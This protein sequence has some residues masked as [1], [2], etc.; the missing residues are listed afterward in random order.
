MLMT[1]QDRGGRELSIGTPA[2]FV[3]HVGPD[4][5]VVRLGSRQHRKHQK[6]AE[7]STWWA[8]RARGWWIA[9][10]FAVGSLLFAVGSVPGYAS[11][12]GAAGDTVTYF[13]G[14]LFFTAASS[15]AAIQL[16]QAEVH[17]LFL[18]P[19]DRER[20][21]YR[22]HALFREFLLGELRRTEPDIVL[23]LHQRAADW[24]EST[25]SPAQAVEHLLQ[26]N[27]QD[28]TA[29]LVTAL[30]LPTYMAGQ[31]S[32]TQRWFRAIGDMNIERYPLLA[33]HKCWECVLTGDTTE[34]LRWAAIVDASSFDGVPANGSASFDSARALLRAAMC[35]AGPEAMTADA[36]FAVA[37][38]P[39]WGPW[40]DTALWGLAE[41][42]LLAGHLDQARALFGEASSLAAEMGNTDNMAACESHLAWLAM[43]RGD[44]QE[45]ACRL[46]AALAAIE[47]KRLHD[48]V[49]CSLAFAGAG[50]L[51][52]HHG[53][54]K[55]ARRQLARAMRARPAATYL[56]PYL[57][58]RLRLR[59]AKVH[60]AIADQGTARQLLREIDDVL[61]HR[62]ALGIL[63]DEVDEFRR[64]LTSSTSSGTSGPLPLTPAELRLLPYL[65]THLTADMIAE[66][67]FLS[68]HTVKTQVKAVYR[69]LGVS[70]RN[71][72][73]QKATAIG[74][75][76]G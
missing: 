49:F 26:T 32:T 60:L 23:T 7:G 66:R 16:R 39:P 33:L 65:Q 67:L 72:A 19:L 8:P 11:A 57:A 24:Y 21:W 3:D 27:D 63:I 6:P 47:E 30:V 18:A 14:S 4:G 61:S 59:L 44:W 53:D 74:L 28:R 29:R 70:S 73:V 58:V 1:G 75:L 2:T 56:V 34:S 40:R 9:I 43:D 76:G 5:S 25:G 22:Y 55:E 35:A 48:Y 51:S 31:L 17:H 52:V 62:P 13:I 37:Q 10:L 45:A 68:V 71:D 36:T 15:A 46:K 69:K 20:Q 42:H 12:V 38:E 41:A 54:L 64:A 50:R